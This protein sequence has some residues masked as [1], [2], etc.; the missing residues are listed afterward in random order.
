MTPKVVNDDECV[1]A[2]WSQLNL[3]LGFYSRIDTKTSLVLGINLGMLAF[4]FSRA[5]PVAQISTLEWAF[6]LP[7]FFAVACT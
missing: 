5:P 4:L 7:F 2:A 1:D 6:A 3:V